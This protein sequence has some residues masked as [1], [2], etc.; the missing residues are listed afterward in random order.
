MHVAPAPREH[1]EWTLYREQTRF[2]PKSGMWLSICK[3][4][5]GFY[6][7]VWFHN[8]NQLKPHTYWHYELVTQRNE[9]GTNTPFP[10]LPEALCA[11]V[12]SV[13]ITNRIN[14]NTVFRDSTRNGYSHVSDQNTRCTLKLGRQ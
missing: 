8:P 14:V 10:S 7:R 11:A 1:I 9:N 4:P 2:T 5:T 6:A 3:A 12:H 13:N